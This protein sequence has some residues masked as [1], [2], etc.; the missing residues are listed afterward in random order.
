MSR[1]FFLPTRTALIGLCAVVAVL[2]ATLVRTAPTTPAAEGLP[3]EQRVRAERAARALWG[4]DVPVTGVER[5]TGAGAGAGEPE[6]VV[7]TSDQG[8]TEFSW[9]GLKPLRGIRDAEASQEKN[10]PTSPTGPVGPDDQQRRA[11]EFMWANFPWA[12]R[13]RVTSWA[14]GDSGRR[15]FSWRRTVESVLMPMRLDVVLDRSGA[16][17]SFAAVDEPDPRL[18]PVEVGEERAVAAAAAARPGV[19]P[20]RPTLLAVQI[21]GAWRAAWSFPAAATEPN[22]LPGASPAAAAEPNASPGAA[23][24]PDRSSGTVPRTLVDASTASVLT[25]T[26]AP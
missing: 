6:T 20:G 17:A 8:Y 5:A 25:W 13:A 14:L 16:V 7:V 18:P 1:L 11:E 3:A 10:T 26:D 19:R 12:D 21:G 23:A 4:R 24:D 22:T 9:P 15:V 2:F